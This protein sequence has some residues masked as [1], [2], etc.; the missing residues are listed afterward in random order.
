MTVQN[1]PTPKK[2]QFSFTWE[3]GPIFPFLDSIYILNACTIKYSDK[4]TSS[5]GL[6]S[7]S[8]M[9]CLNSKVWCFLSFYTREK[10]VSN[11]YIRNKCLIFKDKHEIVVFRRET[12]IWHLNMS[13]RNTIKVAS[14][15]I[16]YIVL[17]KVLLYLC[18]L[19]FY[20]INVGIIIKLNGSSDYFH[21]RSPKYLLKA[22]AKADTLV[23]L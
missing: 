16:S 14:K 2:C 19:Y 8:Y 13:W 5:V 6:E 21:A 18:F 4:L 7:T 12:T 23:S 3:K 9:K 20:I 15:F 17:H 10:L 22:K 1:I 11:L